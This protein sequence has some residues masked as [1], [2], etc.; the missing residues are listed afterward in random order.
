MEGD[1]DR[2]ISLTSGTVFVLDLNLGTGTNPDF[3]QDLCGLTQR[4][5]NGFGE[6][7]EKPLSLVLSLRDALTVE[8]SS[9]Q[10]DKLTV[11]A[12][13][14]GD[15]GDGTYHVVVSGDDNPARL[16]RLFFTGDVEANGSFT[17]E[18]IDRGF[19]AETYVHIFGSE[20]GPLL[21]SI[22]FH[23]SCSAPLVIGDQYG[24]ITLEG[25]MLE[26]KDTGTIYEVAAP[27]MEGDEEVVYEITGGPDAQ[28]FVVDPDSG[29]IN[30]IAPPDHE[31]PID[32][33]QDN[34]YHIQVT[35]FVEGTDGSK[36]GGIAGTSVIEVSVNAFPGR[37]LEGTADPDDLIGSLGDDSIWGYASH[38]RIVGDDGDDILNGGLGA[39][40][41]NGG[42]GDDTTV[43]GPD[44]HEAD[45]RD[46]IYAGAG[47]DLAEGGGGNDQIFGQEGNDTLAGGFGAD[48]LQGQGGDDVI[49]GG[50]LSDLV[51]G[52]AGDDFVNGGFG[53]DRINGGEGADRFFHLGV[54]DHG[55]DWVQDYD[56]AEGDVLVF[57]QAATADQFQVNLAHTATP[58]GDRSGDDDVQEAFVTSISR[59]AGKCSTC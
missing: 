20:G 46:V 10:G 9:S 50:A 52:G 5:I 49:T 11:G 24:S 6:E 12:V 25:A 40:T 7:T 37:V 21:Q 14:S 15:D 38:D 16:D 48:E 53:Y 34:V 18:G 31:N 28:S 41:V 45:Q 26:G 17:A 4:E 55:S 58:D 42:D 19:G 57:G 51:F 56:A 47:D 29:V 32:A 36:S 44:G 39:D 13:M 8:T 43:G 35:A 22:N 33:D 1:V 23:T 30:F 2:S 3:G 27:V 59:S 54:A